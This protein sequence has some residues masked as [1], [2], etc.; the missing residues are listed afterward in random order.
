METNF[1]VIEN[2]VVSNVI[3]IDQND[4]ATIEHF[5]AIEL[6]QGSPIGIGYIYDGANFTAPVVVVTLAEAQ[7]T[8]LDLMDT[9]YEAANTEPIPYMGTTFQADQDS[10]NLIASVITA[11][12]GALPA[13]FVWYDTNNSP[14]PMTFVQL[15]GLAASILMRGQ[16]LFNKKQQLKASIRDASTVAQVEAITW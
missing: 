3:V 8:Q 13:G 7:K 14:V 4:A 10:Q 5:G 2:G 15:Q 16:P 9:S 12:G 1:A 11:C 6:P